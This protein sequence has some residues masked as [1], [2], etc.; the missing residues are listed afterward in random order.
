MGSYVS[1]M[2]CQ[3]DH[4]PQKRKK[5]RSWAQTRKEGWLRKKRQVRTGTRTQNLLLR[6]QAPYPLGHTD[7]H[8]FYVDSTPLHSCHSS[9]G[10]QHS[11]STRK[12]VGSN[13]ACGSRPMCSHVY[14]FGRTG[15]KRRTR[16]FLH[17]SSP[18]LSQESYNHAFGCVCRVSVPGD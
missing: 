6:R 7:V 2:F 14:F 5:E 12:V 15:K 3:I 18:D 9:F 10:V 8:E 4:R 13:P 16:Q 17:Q 1:L 11:L